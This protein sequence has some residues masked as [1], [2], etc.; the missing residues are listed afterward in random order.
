MNTKLLQKRNKKVREMQT[1]VNRGG[2]SS[3][4]S[5][6]YK[7]ELQNRLVEEL[8]EQTLGASELTLTQERVAF[9]KVLRE[10]HGHIK[11]IS[12]KPSILPPIPQPSQP[13][14]QPSQLENL[15]AMLSDPACSDEL[16]SFFQSQNKRGNDE[17]EDDGM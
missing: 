15:R 12:R 6:S 10:R 5:T 8:L 4:N 3:Y 11:G 9:V 2:S 13:S 7:K 14:P 16:Y 17:N 1:N